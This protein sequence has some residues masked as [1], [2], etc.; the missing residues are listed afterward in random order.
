[1]KLLSKIVFLSGFVLFST[2]AFSHSKIPNQCPSVNQ[3]KSEGFTE[4]ELIAD[5]Y[6]A[7]YHTSQYGTDFNWEFSLFFVNAK[8]KERAIAKGNVIVQKLSGN[9][10]PENRGGIWGCDY[11][12]DDEH[13]ALALI[14]S[15]SR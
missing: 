7:V 4:G 14:K 1:M 2:L 9:P 11:T 15:G 6:W 3:I 8:T 12:M 10:E 5:D 13:I